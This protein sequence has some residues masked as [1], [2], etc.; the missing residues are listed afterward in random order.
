MRFSAGKDDSSEAP[1]ASRPSSRIVHSPKHDCSATASKSSDKV[2][3]RTSPVE[4]T[5]RLSKRRKGDVEVKDLDGEV[6]V[7]DRERSTDL[8]SADFDKPGTDEVTSYRTGDKPLDRSKDKGSERH[9]RDY[10]DRLERS[11]KSRADDILT[12]KSRDRSIERHGRECSVERSIDRNLDRLGD[13]A[14]DERSKDERSKVRYADTSVEKSHA[15]DRFHGQSLPPPPPL[16]PHMVPQ[17][18]NA[19]GR[20]D[21]DPDR[22]FGST[23]HTQRLSPRHEEKERRRSEENLLVSQDD[24]KRRREDDFRERKRE[25]REGLSLKVLNWSIIFII[26]FLFFFLCGYPTSIMSYLWSYIQV[27]SLY[28]LLMGFRLDA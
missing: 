19:T 7:S 14:K 15:D 12:E 5:D 10:R 28:L 4:E 8:R 20:R 9:D 16:P 18:V 21:D 11:E 13:K 25:E 1:D 22:R 24:G 6:R 3:K 23:R 17:S 27:E 26:T 2:Q